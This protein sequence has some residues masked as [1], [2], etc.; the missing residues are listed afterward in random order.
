MQIH[1]RYVTIATVI[2]TV[3]TIIGTAAALVYY[4]SLTKYDT[5]EGLLFLLVGY[6]ILILGTYNITQWRLKDVERE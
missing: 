6:T 4:F 5:T 2:M 1:E 3:L